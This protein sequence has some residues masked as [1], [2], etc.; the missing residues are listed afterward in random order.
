MEAEPPLL[1]TS[2]PVITVSSEQENSVPEDDEPVTVN[3]DSRTLSGDTVATE[4][5]ETSNGEKEQVTADLVVAETPESSDGQLEKENAALR[6]ELFQLR[7]E[8]DEAKSEVK[9]NPV[10]ICSFFYLALFIRLLFHLFTVGSIADPGCL[11]RILIFI[12]PGG[13]QIPDPTTPPKEGGKFCLSYHFFC[14]N[15]IKL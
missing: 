3:S 8:L 14:N 12:H 5:T 7:R 4:V 11:S 13:S 9:G 15:K 1:E 6:S 2:P 10:S